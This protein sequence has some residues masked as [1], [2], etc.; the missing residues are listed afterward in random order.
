MTDL[1]NVDTL[2]LL[3]AEVARIL[4][5]ASVQTDIGLGEIGIDSLNVVELIVF[6][7]QLYN[8]ADP[9]KLEIGQYTTLRD[10]DVQLRAMADADAALAGAEH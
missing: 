5:V 1:R 4:N 6:C 8:G 10:I 3:G 2:T 9:L 7:G